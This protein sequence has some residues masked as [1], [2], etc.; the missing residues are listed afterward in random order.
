V[1]IV[2]LRPTGPAAY[3]VD[4]DDGARTVR[5][6]VTVPPGFAASVGWPDDAAAALVEASIAFLLAREPAPAILPRFTLAQITGYF[7][8]YP[9]EMRRHRP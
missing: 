9:D 5:L 7:P 8:E 6:S 4:V 1:A 2:S 3:A